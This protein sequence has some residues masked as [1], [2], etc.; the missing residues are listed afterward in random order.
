MLYKCTRILNRFF[1]LHRMFGMVVERILITDMAKVSGERDRKIVTIG[2]T[3]ILC[4]CPTMLQQP[5]LSFWPVLLQTLIQIFELPPDDNLLEG[6]LLAADNET[7]YQAAFS[8][9]NYAQPLQQDPFSEI[10][11]ARKY[12]LDQLVK[13][14]TVH[15][16][17]IAGCVRQ[18]PADHQQALEKYSAQYGVRIF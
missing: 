12:L 11:D 2:V 7:G 10:G 17:T 3:R 14:G 16:S 6:D 15:A 13:L 4:E 5:Y 1:T 9:L 8:Q 18:M